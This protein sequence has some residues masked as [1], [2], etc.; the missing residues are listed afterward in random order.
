MLIEL[1]QRLAVRIVSDASLRLVCDRLLMNAVDTIGHV[2]I[3]SLWEP[4]CAGNH[5]RPIFSLA[6]LDSRA[7]RVL[8]I[9]TQQASINGPEDDARGNLL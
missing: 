1:A 7:S 2:L 6:A 8:S 5:F 3:C 4:W 9:E